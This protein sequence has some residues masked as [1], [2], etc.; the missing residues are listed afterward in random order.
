MRGDT[1]HQQA[2]VMLDWMFVEFDRWFDDK[3]V[4]P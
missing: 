1:G 3:C 2:E 4:G